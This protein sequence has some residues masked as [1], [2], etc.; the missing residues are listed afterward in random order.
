MAQAFERTMPRLE[1][2]G[3]MSSAA[4]KRFFASVS[5]RRPWGAKAGSS[6]P[7]MLLARHNPSSE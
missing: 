7:E 1:L 5:I 3:V 2:C 6:Q 4:V